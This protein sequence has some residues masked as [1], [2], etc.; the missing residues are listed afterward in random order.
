MDVSTYG[1]RRIDSENVALFAENSRHLREITHERDILLSRTVHGSPLY[2]NDFPQKTFGSCRRLRQRSNR[3]SHP[4]TGTIVFLQEGRNHVFK[5]TFEKGSKKSKLKLPI[6]QG[7]GSFALPSS[8]VGSLGNPLS[9]LS[10]IYSIAILRNSELFEFSSQ[11][12]TPFFFMSS[13]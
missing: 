5:Q 4:F 7:S 9:L 2:S 1:T 13:K 11:V 3:M 10:S 12:R 6:A 8:L